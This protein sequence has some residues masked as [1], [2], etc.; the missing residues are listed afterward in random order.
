[1]AL[2][3]RCTALNLDTD[4][5]VVTATVDFLQLGFE[6]DGTQ[7]ARSNYADTVAEALGLLHQ[8]SCEEKTALLFAF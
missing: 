1:M 3:R 8:V 6:A 4:G 2:F 7:V 5:K